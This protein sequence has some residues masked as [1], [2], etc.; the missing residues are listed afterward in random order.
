MPCVLNTR[1]VNMFNILGDNERCRQ[2]TG[3][4]WDVFITTFYHLK[5]ETEISLE[6]Q[7]LWKQGFTTQQQFYITTH[8]YHLNNSPKTLQIDNR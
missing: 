5:P 2:L 8:I 1:L 7:G 6:V 3:L 4:T